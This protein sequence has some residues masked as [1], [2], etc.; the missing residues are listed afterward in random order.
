MDVL[1]GRKKRLIITEP[2]RHGK[3]EFWSKYFPAFFLGN[4]PDQRV[5]LTSYEAGFASTWGRKTRD[6]LEDWGEQLFG[7]TVDRSSFSVSDWNLEGREGGMSTAGIGG[8]ITGRGAN[9]FIIDD[10]TKNAKE[11]QSELVREAQWDWYTS[12]ARTRVEPGGTIIVIMTRWHEDDLAGR[13][14]QSAK[15]DPEADQWEVI[16]LPALAEAGDVL[17]RAE[18]EALF[19]ERYDVEALRKIKATIG[20]YWWSA[21]FQGSPRPMEGNLFKRDWWKFYSVETWNRWQETEFAEFDEIVQSWDCAFKGLET[22]SYVCGEVWGKVGPNKYLLDEVREKLG[23]KGTIAAI[24]TLSAKWPQARKK[25][26]E[27]KANGT[28][29]QELLEGE[30]SGIVMVEPKGGKEARAMAISGDVEAGNVYLP[31]KE[32]WPNVHDFIGEFASFPNGKYS[33]RVDCASQCIVRWVIK[34]F[35]PWAA[36]LGWI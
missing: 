6:L 33:D 22:S 20:S 9:L 7:V 30:I 27:D 23:V 35:K 36:K 32:L 1:G 4:F 34:G 21:L 14:L 26:I 13:L 19:P 15:E 28:A 16:N 8:P 3:S 5:I 29:V 2:P 31:C 12:T 17:G 24:R 10:P 25:L 18:G 11:A